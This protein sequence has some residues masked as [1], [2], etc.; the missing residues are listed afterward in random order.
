MMPDEAYPP[1]NS[2][3]HSNKTGKCISQHCYS[4]KTTQLERIQLHDPDCYVLCL[5]IMQNCSCA[6]APSSA[7]VSL[8]APSSNKAHT[9]E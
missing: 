4:K 1:I 8:V 3:H 5:N 9:P 2:Y 7:D 6:E